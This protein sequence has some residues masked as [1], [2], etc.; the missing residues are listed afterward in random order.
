MRGYQY[1]YSRNHTCLYDVQGRERKAQTMVDV[2]RD[3][4][5]RP[6]HNLRV[7]NVG[8]SA[9]IID[10]ILANHFGS[11]IGVDIDAAAIR[12]A[13]HTYHRENLDFFIGDALNLGF[14]DN[15][16]DV[17]VCSQVYEHVPDPRR[18]MDEIFRMLVPGG[19]CYFAATSRLIWNEPHY[20]LPLLSVF[21]R[22]MAHWYVRLMG[23]ASHYY[24]R[25]YYYPGL[26][27]LVRNFMVH[28]YTAKLIRDPEKY[29][30]SYMFFPGSLKAS[31]A[32]FIAGHCRW[33]NP[34]YI[35]LLEKPDAGVQQAARDGYIFIPE[36]NT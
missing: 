35:W 30:F 11:V 28:D 6:L 16:F 17:V 10:N 15:A 8:G 23:K 26:K 19:V 18:M 4:L 12:H 1:D 21:P 25:L 32:G 5:A 31:I 3:F 33:L 7:L 9:G 34:G 36:E 22:P 27:N 24:E 13:R 14:A 29:S 20:N 2:F